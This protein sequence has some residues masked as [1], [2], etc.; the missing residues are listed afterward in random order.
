[1]YIPGHE[2][3]TDKL[4]KIF[5]FTLVI[6]FVG[7]CTFAMFESVLFLLFPNMPILFTSMFP[8][9]T[10]LLF[11]IPPLM[12][13]IYTVLILYLATCTIFI[14]SVY[15]GVL[16]VPFVVKELRLD[17]RRYRSLSKLREM[18]VL[19]MEYRAAE[20]L[21]RIFNNHVGRF[22]LV[23]Q[24]LASLMFM[25]CGF[26]IVKHG[27]DMNTISFCLLWVWLL[28][29]AGIWSGWLAACAY[30]STH[31]LKILNSW[32]YHV[33]ARNHERVIMKKF[34]LSCKPLAVSYKNMYIIRSRSVL[35][36]I[37]GLLRGLMRTLLTL[38]T[39]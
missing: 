17:R 7:G 21:Q 27:G 10:S 36:F 25:I 37:Q 12:F 13:H 4:T 30:F 8:K 11:H 20:I 33:W 16:V 38:R 29:S 22:L 26:M 34:R 14:D 9:G 6:L 1:M 31:G 28:G 3:N 35:A 2:P 23:F 19:K 32:K 15:Y 18:H 39:S 5:D 24:S